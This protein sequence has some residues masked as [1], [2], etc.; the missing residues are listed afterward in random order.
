MSLFITIY[1][2]AY[3]TLQNAK[4]VDEDLYRKEAPTVDISEDRREENFRLDINSWTLNK[5]GQQVPRADPAGASTVTVDVELSGSS[6]DIQL[7]PG[8]TT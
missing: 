4:K 7:N 3:N 8:K 1:I 5:H 6:S 2:D